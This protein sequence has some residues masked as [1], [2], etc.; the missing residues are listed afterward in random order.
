MTHTI[1]QYPLLP[2]AAGIF[3]GEG[4]FF[5][6]H[7]DDGIYPRAVLQMT[8]ED[9]IRKFQSVI[10]FGRVYQRRPK[11]NRSH[12]KASWAWYV[13]SFE[14]FQQTVC[15]L[16]PWLCSRRR[17]KIKEIMMNY[18]AVTEERARNPMRQPRRQ[19][20]PVT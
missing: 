6:D 5:E 2:W 14:Y 13:N 9:V 1:A 8:D 7:T 19:R 16:W 10:G 17:A 11:G 3:E 15:Y 20:R 18:H 4:S 12:H